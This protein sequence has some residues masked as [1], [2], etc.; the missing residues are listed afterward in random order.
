M[1]IISILLYSPQS[2]KEHAKRFIEQP[3]LPAYRP[4]KG[5][6]VSSEVGAGIK[7]IVIYEFNKSK[8]SEAMEVLTARYAKYYG[9]P[10]FTYSANTLNNTNLDNIAWLSPNSFLLRYSFGVN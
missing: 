2:T 3:P 6:Q 7:S 10:G 5:P 8:V 1:V 9:V 4:M